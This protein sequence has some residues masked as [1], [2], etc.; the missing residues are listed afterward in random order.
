[1]GVLDQCIT[2]PHAYI[3]TGQEAIVGLAHGVNLP[4]DCVMT[5]LCPSD[6]T[7]LPW[8]MRVR[9]PVAFAALLLA[10]AAGDV[11]VALCLAVSLT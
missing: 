1:M 6:N 3:C 2:C 10:G 11:W 8:L 5:W 4:L 7:C 9:P